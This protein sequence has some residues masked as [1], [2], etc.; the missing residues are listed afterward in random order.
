VLCG[1]GDRPPLLERLAPVADIRYAEHAREALPAADVLL[2]WDF[3]AHTV[4]D[5]WDQADRLRWVHVAAAGVDRV[6]FPELVQSDVVV[7]NAR[8][9][10]DRPIAEYVLMCV[11]AH[12]KGLYRSR[13]LQRQRH[14]EHRETANI[15]GASVLVVGTGAIGRAIARLLRAAG[16]EVKGAGRTAREGDPDFGSVLASSDLAAYLPDAD[17]L[18]L[19][20]PLTPQTRGLIDAGALSRLKPSAFLVNVGRGACVEQAALRAALAEG[21]LA[22]AALDVFESEPLPAG[23][24][25]WD[26][27]GVFISPHMSG[28]FAGSLEL[29]AGQ[30]IENVHRWTSGQPLRN[31]VDK[32]LGFVDQAPDRNE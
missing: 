25:L 14:W 21:R 15:S 24:P 2:A 9:V 7:T 11:L 18:V 3:A 6:L 17:Y 1:A 4:R 13:D 31:V 12:A 19:A 10:F 8:G 22:G 23:D 20:A 26:A 30:F 5:G 29:L 32:S 27:P 16:M 28:D